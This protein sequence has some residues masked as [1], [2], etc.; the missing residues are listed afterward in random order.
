MSNFVFAIETIA[1]T[2]CFDL[3]ASVLLFYLVFIL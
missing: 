2:S 1:F 3:F